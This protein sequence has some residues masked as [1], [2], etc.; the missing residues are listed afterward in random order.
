[1]AI[2][3]ILKMVAENLGKVKVPMNEIQDI[4]LPVA[5]AIHALKICIDAIEAA[6]AKMKPELEIVPVEEDKKDE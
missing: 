6:E 4:G 1:M 3:D 5:D 2:I